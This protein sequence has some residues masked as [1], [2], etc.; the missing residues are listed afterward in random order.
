MVRDA[1][2][3]SFKRDLENQEKAAGRLTGTAV[4]DGGSEPAALSWLLKFLSD[5][6]REVTQLNDWQREEAFWETWR[7]AWDGGQGPFTDIGRLGATS[8]SYPQTDAERAAL[9]ADI[10]KNARAALTDFVTTGVGTFP[11]MEAAFSVMRQGSLP[12]G[13][14]GGTLAASFYYM[15]A[16]LLAR[17][18]HRVK[19]CE[20]CHL[21]MLVGRKDQRFHSQACQIGTFI[22]KKRAAEKTARLARELK[23]TKRERKPTRS[24]QKG[25]THGRD[26]KA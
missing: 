13:Y 10:Q 11:K 9:V 7:F 26:K 20:G 3:E 14:R 21:V 23:R 17:Y 22:R 25:G 19:P 5:S 2:L 15:A 6:D 16:Q 24:Q 18:R 12:L 8:L 4:Y 1:A